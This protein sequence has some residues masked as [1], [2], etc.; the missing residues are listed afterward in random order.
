MRRDGEG[1]YYDL[2]RRFRR[3][4]FASAFAA[5][6][7]LIPIV[8]KFSWFR[9]FYNYYWVGKILFCHG[10]PYRA[11]MCFSGYQYS[12]FFAFSFIPFA[13]LRIEAAAAVWFIISACAFV[14]M[15]AVAGY[16]MAPRPEGFSAWVAARTV[17]LFKEGVVP[18]LPAAAVLLAF[19]YI[20]VTFHMGQVTFV[21]FAMVLTAVLLDYKGKLFWA[22]VLLGF[23][24]AVK[25]VAAVAL[26]FFIL[27]RR[28][29]VMLG[30]CASLVAACA[31]PALYVGWDKNLK[32]WAAW[33]EKVVQPAV[34]KDVVF[35]LPNNQSVGAVIYRWIY[36]MPPSLWR[37]VFLPRV[38]EI[39]LTLLVIFYLFLTV[40]AV[41][42]CRRRGVSAANARRVD[43]LLLSS[44]I[45]GGILL[46]PSAWDHY[47]A[48]ATFA[49]VTA[50]YCVW[51]E[52]GS[53][54]KWIIISLLGAGGRRLARQRR[55]GAGI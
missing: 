39:Y 16:I 40:L 23:A 52:R 38:Q 18:L 51:A 46:L 29:A 10:D 24:V 30:F 6:I 19:P 25:P 22:G 11:V 7:I 1:I 27:R 45:V 9:D 17:S 34:H 50:V 20:L 12:P 26:P 5:F 49:F 31:I 33:W 32:L 13:G 48:A 35:A 47:F 44:F 54:V 36:L 2:P 53:A 55:L 4:V 43:N 15:M 14:W 42:S 3:A 21:I 41:I 8:G 37:A 28:V